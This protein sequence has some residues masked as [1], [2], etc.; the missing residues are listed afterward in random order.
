[1]TFRQAPENQPTESIKT[2]LAHSEQMIAEW[3]WS[4]KD[5][6]EGVLRA[7]KALEYWRKARDE[8]KWQIEQREQEINGL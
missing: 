3:A 8:Q 1:M 6:E 2:M 7:Q 5:H 4:L